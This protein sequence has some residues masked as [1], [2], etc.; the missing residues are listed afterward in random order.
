MSEN[1]TDLNDRQVKINL[2]RITYP[3]Q[4]EISRG[5]VVFTKSEF[6][7]DLK[8]HNKFNVIIRHYFHYFSILHI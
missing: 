7:F 5:A 3:Q 8:Q 1:G 4:K 6:T 2:V